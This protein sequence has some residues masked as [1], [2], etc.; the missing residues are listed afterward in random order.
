MLEV[1]DIRIHKL[2]E[3]GKVRA[4]LSLTIDN[5]IVIHDIKILAGSSGL[6]MA[7]PGRKIAHD[8]FRNTVHPVSQPVRAY[9]EQQVLAKYRQAL[10]QEAGKTSSSCQ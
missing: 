6:F 4:I 5:A 7:M 10:S 1:T 3:T 9:L 2:V 8:Q